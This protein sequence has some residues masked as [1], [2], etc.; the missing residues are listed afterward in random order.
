MSKRARIT[1]NPEM[2]TEP[3][4]AT[5]AKSAPSPET[6]SPAHNGFAA[7]TNK[8]SRPSPPGKRALNVGTIVKVV[9]AGL[10]V[11][12]LVLLWKN[13]RL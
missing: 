12:S 11:A 8:P 1:L 4:Q 7:A 5:Q 6:E 9:F 13:R 2:E 3:N 10:A